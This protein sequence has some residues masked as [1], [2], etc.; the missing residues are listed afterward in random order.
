[1]ASEVPTNRSAVLLHGF[2]GSSASWGDD[3]LGSVR[4]AGFSPAPID[5][6]GHGQEA[7]GYAEPTLE[8]A[9]G[10]VDSALG[11][12]PGVL[13][14]YSMGGRIALHYAARHPERV[15]RL[16]LESSTAGLRTEAE[17][18]TRQMADEAIA[19]RLFA[20]GIEPFVAYW[21]SLPIFDTQRRMDPALRA[22]LR[23]RRM[24]NDPGG[25]GAALRGLGTGSLPSLWDDLGR[26][27][28]PVL[29]LVG[30]LDHKFCNIGQ[31]LE[32]GLP[33]ARLVTVPDAG[34][35]I[36]LEAPWAWTQAVEEFLAEG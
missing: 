17:R 8:S 10:I 15:E 7:I 2:T 6:P 25:L 19:S 16:V 33:D 1:M 3:L 11:S 4:R 18:R 12:T 30:E 21:E 9:L 29:I 20:D 36:H 14:G 35:A 23:R 26:I 24:R 28:V 27:T 22:A 31:D 32:A 34:H 13:I 5:L